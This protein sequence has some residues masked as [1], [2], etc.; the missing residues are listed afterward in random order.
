[1]LA[2]L[3]GILKGDP[4]PDRHERP[5]EAAPRK[6]KLGLALSS[7]GARG[8]AHGGADDLLHEALVRLL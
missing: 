6:P 4:R 7:G 8:L 2:K 3:L 1:M 5:L